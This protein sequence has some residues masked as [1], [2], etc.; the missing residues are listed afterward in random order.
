MDSIY[1]SAD[2]YEERLC[3]VFELDPGDPRRQLKAHIVAEAGGDLLL[4]SGNLNWITL[5]PSTLS[6]VC[7]LDQLLDSKDGRRALAAWRA[8]DDSQAVKAA[9][10]DSEAGIELEKQERAAGVV[11]DEPRLTLVREQRQ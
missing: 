7:T 8:G 9:R 4:P 1:A 11:R 5:N 3:R 6:T 10:L 2:G